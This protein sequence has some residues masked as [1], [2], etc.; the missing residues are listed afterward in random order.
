MTYQQ[1][2]VLVLDLCQ[3]IDTP[4]HLVFQ[5][6]V[7]SVIEFSFDLLAKYGKKTEFKDYVFDLMDHIKILQCGFCRMDNFSKIPTSFVAGWIAE[8]HLAISRCFPHIF[9][10]VRKLIGDDKPGI[11]YYDMMIQSLQ[12]IVAWLMAPVSSSK[13]EL[14]NYIKCFL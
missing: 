8:N 9:S 6:I 13:H 14:N 4:M 5:G 2:G 1:C 3:L 7:K 10:Y 12:Y 11:N